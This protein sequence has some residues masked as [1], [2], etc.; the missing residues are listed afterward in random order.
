MRGFQLYKERHDGDAIAAEQWIAAHQDANDV[1]L[2][3]FVRW[4][5]QAGTPTVTFRGSYD[6][7]NKQ[8]T[9]EVSQHTA[10]TPSEPEKVR[11]AAQLELHYL[12]CP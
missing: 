1:D 9:L 7:T 11:R 4:Y 2:S 3:Q 10:P 5:D 6:A 8:Y 12:S